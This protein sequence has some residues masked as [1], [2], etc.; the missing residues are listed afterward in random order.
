M[1]YFDRGLSLIKSGHYDKRFSA[2][3]ESQPAW[4]KSIPH[5]SQ[6]LFNPFPG[7][8][9]ISFIWLQDPFKSLSYGLG[10]RT[11]TRERLQ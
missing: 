5:A 9:Y 2:T 7:H 3:K 1:K 4:P 11:I 6:L 10:N 8:V